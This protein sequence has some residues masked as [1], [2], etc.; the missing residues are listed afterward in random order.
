MES[1]DLSTTEE[2]FNYVSQG[3][4]AP[5]T[6]TAVAFTFGRLDPLVPKK[7]AELYRRRLVSKVLFTGGVGKDSGALAEHGIPEAVYCAIVANTRGVLFEDIL[8]EKKAHNGA[9]NCEYGLKTLLHAL[10]QATRLTVVSHALSARR[11]TAQLETAARR[12]E[13]EFD[14]I[15]VVP[16]DYEPNPQN[17]A[18]VREAAEELARLVT[19]PHKRGGDGFVWIT[20]HLQTLPDP[21]PAHLVALAERIL[22]RQLVGA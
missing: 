10:P 1:P 5:L 8:I 22:G 19:W 14:K 16:T 3:T 4:P 7:A 21:V 12:I 17:L 18:D 13:R 15:Q 9:E 2:M 20:G 6:P 11:L